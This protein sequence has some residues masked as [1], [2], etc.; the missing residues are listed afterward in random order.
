[1]IGTAVTEFPWPFKTIGLAAG[2]AAVRSHRR[3][4]LSQ[5]PVTS[6]WLSG[7]IASETINHSWPFK[8]IGLAA[9]L[10]AVRSHR[11]AVL[12]R[13]AVTSQWLSGLTARTETESS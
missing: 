4:V 5:L 3:A 6:Q 1:M 12:S 10:A 13:L 8:T 11:R 2:S 9:G 7:L